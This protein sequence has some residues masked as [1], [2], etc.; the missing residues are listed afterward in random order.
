MKFGI[1]GVSSVFFGVS[2]VF[3]VRFFFRQFVTTRYFR[4]PSLTS[5]SSLSFEARYLKVW[6]HTVSSLAKNAPFGY[7]N[8]VWKLRNE[9][10]T[11]MINQIGLS[12]LCH[13]WPQSLTS[14]ISGPWQNIKNWLANFQLSSFKTEVTDGQTDLAYSFRSLCSGR[15]NLCVQNNQKEFYQTFTI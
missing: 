6:I 13:F 14:N 5:N 8:F 3:F 11:K 12:W 9:G 1:F 7:S 15:I 10:F 4:S 2:S